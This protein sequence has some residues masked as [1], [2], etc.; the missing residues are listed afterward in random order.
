MTS[1]I[2]FNNHNNEALSFSSEKI[3]SIVLGE[4]YKS[5]LENHGKIDSSLY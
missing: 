5:G 3:E 4:D 2:T 1:K